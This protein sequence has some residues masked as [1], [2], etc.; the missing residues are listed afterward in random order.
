MGFFRREQPL[1]EK[2]AREGGL[3]FAREVRDLA[4]PDPIDPRHPFWQVTGIHGIPREREWDAVSSAEA[5]NLPGDRLE[6]VALEDGTLFTDEDLP[7]DALVPLADALE[8]RVGAPYHAFAVRQ[9]DEVW[10]VAALR[11]AVVE[12]PEGVE[13]DEVD[14]VVNDGERQILVDEAQSKAE[15]P[16]LEEFAAQQFGSFVLHASRLDDVLWEVTV[17]PL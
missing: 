16:S 15:V 5:P 1:H 3:D 14:L 4:P 8:G 13:G 6:F 12:V 9:E 11:V 10:S 17:L 2:L 7:E